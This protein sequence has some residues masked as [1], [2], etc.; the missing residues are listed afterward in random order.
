SLWRLTTTHFSRIDLNWSKRLP[1]DAIS[2]LETPPRPENDPNS[3][4]VD[5]SIIECQNQILGEDIPLTGTGLTLHYQSERT[6]GRLLE[7]AVHIPLSGAAVPAS[8]S[9]IVLD[10]DIA[11]QHIETRYPPAPNLATT[12]VWDGKD[13]FG[14]PVLGTKKATIRVT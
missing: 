6:H 13:G 2:P 7:R 12:F 8:L 14:R 10:V 11:G 5:G 1:S 4:T 9:A 3:C